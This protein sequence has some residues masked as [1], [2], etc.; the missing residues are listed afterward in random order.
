MLLNFSE[1]P[2]IAA[3]QHVRCIF[4]LL[5]SHRDNSGKGTDILTMLAE[6]A[7]E[8]WKRPLIIPYFDSSSTVSWR[9]DLFIRVVHIYY[10]LLRSQDFPK[11]C[12]FR[13]IKHLFHTLNTHYVE[14]ENH[15]PALNFYTSSVGCDVSPRRSIKRHKP[16]WRLN[17]KQK[18]ND[19][20]VGL[21]SS[22]LS[23][24]CYSK[25][26]IFKRAIMTS[27]ASRDLARRW[28]FV[29]SRCK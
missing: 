28:L 5:K 4:E 3:S 26:F 10:P 29:R 20:L 17:N 14:D 8:F 1:R 13:E 15:C 2:L 16:T 7:S 11:I 23:R 19:P 18:Q 9:E 27:A 25:Y 21:F 6:S 22:N 24:P 12:S